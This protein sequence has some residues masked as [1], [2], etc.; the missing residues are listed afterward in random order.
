MISPGRTLAE[1]TQA[2][3]ASQR[4]QPRADEDRNISAMSDREIIARAKY[5]I[6]VVVLG[7]VVLGIAPF[8][9]LAFIFSSF[10]KMFHGG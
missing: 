8:A 2:A 6:L 7:I 1:Q 4:D 10:A 5:V 9:F 3:D